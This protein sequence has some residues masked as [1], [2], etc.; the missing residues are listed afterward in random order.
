M[1]QLAISHFLKSAVHPK[2]PT[3]KYILHITSI[4]GH[5]PVFVGPLYSIT[6]HGVSALVQSLA[7][8]D[9]G[10]NIRVVGVAPGITKTPIWTESEDDKTALLDETVDEWVS[11]DDVATVMLALVERD[12]ISERLEDI[13]QQ[14]SGGISIKGGTIL[15]VS[16]TVR[17]V[18]VFN[19]P[20]P[21][22]RPGNTLGNMGQVEESILQ[23]LNGLKV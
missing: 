18:S 23:M 20:G 9:D 2:E 11:P 4:A 21:V 3:K 19:D 12:N 5:M 7:P 14:D 1:T 6:K 8:L 22:G 13:G 17:S 16:K 10:L 15:E